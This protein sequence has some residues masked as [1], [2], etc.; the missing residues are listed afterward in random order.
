VSPLSILAGVATGYGAFVI[1][2]GIA[3][4]I[5]AAVGGDPQDLT[6]GDWRTVGIAAAIG[7]AVI[8]FVAYFCGGYV[9]GRMAA[10]SGALNGFLVFVVAVVL[11]AL[12]GVIANALTDGEQVAEELRTL[13]VPTSGDE[14]GSIAGI[15]GIVTL[16]L[17]IAGA[18]LGGMQ[19]ERWHGRLV[20]RA[21]DP[22]VGPSADE[23]DVRV[24]GDRDRRDDRGDG[25]Y[26]PAYDR[27][28][29]YDR[30][31]DRDRDYDAE[32][33]AAA[34]RYPSTRE[35][36]DHPRS[37]DAA[38]RGGY[39]DRG[40]QDEGRDRYMDDVPEYR[41]DAPPQTEQPPAPPR[42]RDW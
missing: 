37:G 16:I 38:E 34:T 19:G 18:V 6:S 9:A 7:A 31:Y 12:A 26:D 42:R 36:S 25:D 41:A 22:M 39:T 21:V 28:R 4:T 5:V 40:Y 13:G 30:S 33:E 32:R 29:D 1:L 23:D 27:D 3:A 15:A 35:E 8:A 14:W 20:R 10:R 17:M 11:A 24:V 2:L